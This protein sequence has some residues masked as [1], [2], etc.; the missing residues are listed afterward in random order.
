LP[1]LFNITWDLKDGSSE[2]LAMTAIPHFSHICIEGKDKVVI[3]LLTYFKITIGC[4][5]EYKN[6][7]RESKMGSSKRENEKACIRAKLK[8]QY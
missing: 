4:T 6:T 8:L 2:T 3:N 1:V 5:Y 7:D